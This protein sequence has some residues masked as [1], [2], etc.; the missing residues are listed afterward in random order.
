MLRM[1]V[2]LS[3]AVLLAVR[4]PAFPQ[5]TPPKPLVFEAEDYTTPKD[6]WEAN[7][8]SAN[9]WN[10]WSTDTDAAKKWSGGVVLQSPKVEA[11]RATP[12]DGAPPLHT[13][14]TGIP[15]GRYQ[16]EIKLSRALGVSRDSLK[17]ITAE[18]DCGEDYLLER[19]AREEFGFVRPNERVYLI[20]DDPEDD[21]CIGEAAARGGERFSDRA[22]RA[23]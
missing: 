5:E 1:N 14:L 12:E 21:R 17:L 22:L 2:V 23:R 19:R 10:L 9:K 11:D 3:A 7:K 20:P 4:A 8:S 16:V 13:H 6:A 18:L 15:P